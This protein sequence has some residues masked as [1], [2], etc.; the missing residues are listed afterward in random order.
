MLTDDE[1]LKILQDLS[2]SYDESINMILELSFPGE[3]FNIRT[4][5]LDPSPLTIY[6]K[7][8]VYEK[9]ENYF[10]LF[11]EDIYF[12]FYKTIYFE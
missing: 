4:E 9:I 11:L 3:Y 5:G 8:G 1:I 12:D 7:N 6:D 2:Y 10:G